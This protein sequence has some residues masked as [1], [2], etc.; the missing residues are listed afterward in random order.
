[1]ADFED[2]EQAGDP[3]PEKT[4]G[5]LAR[6]GGRVLAEAGRQLARGQ[7]KKTAAKVGLRALVGALAGA[8]PEIGLILLIIV[9]ILGVVLIV[10]ITI[11]SICNA[12]GMKGRLAR[13]ASSY[14]L[15]V[16]VCK[17]FSGFSS[18]AADFVDRAEVPPVGGTYCGADIHPPAAAVMDCATCV[19]LEDRG[20]PVKA[21][22]APGSTNGANPFADPRMA[23]ALARLLSI[24]QTFIITEAYC[25]TVNHDDPAHYNG[26]A[27]DM[28]PKPQYAGDRAVAA[29]LYRDVV[30]L[31]FA[32][33]VC[34]YPAGYLDAYGITCRQFEQTTGGHIH[35]HEP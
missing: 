24:N 26:T 35:V 30:S 10:I 19:N 23:D 20:I 2:D 11:A 5:Q 32:N 15:P 17:A 14:V 34:E 28:A 31:G 18:Q 21:R 16:D 8:L 33:V 4:P 6:Q 13:T 7:I 1:M 3:R 25:P 12:R 29:K 27:V 22:P 9:L